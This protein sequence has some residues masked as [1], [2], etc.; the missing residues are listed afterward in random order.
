MEFLVVEARSIEIENTSGFARYSPFRPKRNKSLDHCLFAD[1]D[2]RQ[3]S[4]P[5]CYSNLTLPRAM[6]CS[7]FR[8]KKPESMNSG[9][10]R[11]FYYF[12]LIDHPANLKPETL[13]FELGTSNLIY[14]ATS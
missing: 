11:E 4:N 14:P 1:G 9:E 12:Q 2:S 10:F 5:G 7:P 6:I 8:A 3:F 13:N